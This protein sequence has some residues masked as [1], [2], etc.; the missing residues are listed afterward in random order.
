M[1]PVSHANSHKPKRVHKPPAPPE[2]KYD[3]G[4]QPDRAAFVLGTE[5]V[6][7]LPFRHF[8][9]DPALLQAVFLGVRGTTKN[10]VFIELDFEG[11]IGGAFVDRVLTTGYSLSP[12]NL[13][14][15][16][17][18]SNSRPVVGADD[19]IA[20]LLG[21]KLSVGGLVA[22][23]WRLFGSLGLDWF[24]V[25]DKNQSPS[26]DYRKR[27]LVSTMPVDL[28]L[29]A[30]YYLNKGVDWQTSLGYSAEFQCSGKLSHGI[31]WECEDSSKI[32]INNAAVLRTGFVWGYQPE[33]SVDVPVG[34]SV[35]IE[36]KKIVLDQQIHF[37]FNG[38]E[39]DTDD[40]MTV[41]MLREIGDIIFDNHLVV[42]IEGNTDQRGDREY[43]RQLSIDRARN[44]RDY[45][46][47]LTF[48]KKNGEYRKL[49]PSQLRSVG[50]GEDKPLVACDPN[51]PDWDDPDCSKNRR[52][53]FKIIG[54]N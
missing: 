16:R 5:T 24:T 9:A 20:F 54:N 25:I 3:E 46:L 37:K 14:S 15:D 40:L 41:K 48:M 26:S 38:A 47:R 28:S 21:A 29:G 11:A 1:A 44:V 53:T 34:K 30:R 50:F 19:T 17:N 33:P 35:R 10:N 12:I 22:P 7:R 27:F 49:E 36:G 51:N 39:I 31:I 18:Y 8:G 2:P 4:Y 43:N 13:N 52:V 23:R 45:L 32:Y 42:R 6:F